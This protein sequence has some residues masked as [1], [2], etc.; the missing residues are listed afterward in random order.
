MS[1]LYKV[2]MYVLDVN[3][4]YNDLDEIIEDAERRSEFNLKPFN[5]QSV[6]FEWDDDIDLNHK[7]DID[8]Y[9]NYFRED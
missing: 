5:A 9:R 7:D 1:K 8:T 3:D 6:E 4:M 2:E